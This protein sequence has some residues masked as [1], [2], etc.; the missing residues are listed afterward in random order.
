[1]GY[2]SDSMPHIGEVPEKQ[3]QYILG[4]FNGHGMPVIF[5]SA[6]GIAEMIR[7]GKS[8]EETGMPKLFKTSKSR[9][10]SMR[11]DIVNIVPRV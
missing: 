5:L 8:F 3:G 9:L 1:M 6:K 10:E 11:N 2:T 7:G 4:G